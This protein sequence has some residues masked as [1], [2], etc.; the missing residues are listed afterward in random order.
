VA[1][2]SGAVKRGDQA[3]AESCGGVARLR[4]CCD[5]GDVVVRLREIAIVIAAKT[6]DCLLLTSSSNTTPT[7]M[8]ASLAFSASLRKGVGDYMWK[9]FCDAYN[10]AYACYDNDKLEECLQKCHLILEQ[11]AELPRYIR[12][13]TLILVCLIVKDYADF[14]EA[15]SEARMCSPLRVTVIIRILLTDLW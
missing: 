11:Q 13:S 12:I 4:V 3:A 7:T 9:F 6:V 2:R 10:E 14:Y 15:R 5:T 1:K 8:A